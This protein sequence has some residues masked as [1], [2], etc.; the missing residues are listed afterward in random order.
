MV[1]EREN[2]KRLPSP[3]R[4]I[5]GIRQNDVRVRVTGTVVDSG[6][7][8]IAL[9]DGTGKINISLES[10]EGIEAGSVVRVF[11]KVIPMEG[12]FELQGEVLQ[13]MSGLDMALAKRAGEIANI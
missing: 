7:G 5:G 12:G 4:K 10:A 2:I 13:D 3:E 8:M 11:G 6:Q 9:D 1:M